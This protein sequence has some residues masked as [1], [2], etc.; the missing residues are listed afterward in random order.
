MPQKRVEAYDTRTGAKLP[1]RVPENWLRIFPYLSLTPKS[2]A[3]QSA[4]S[5]DVPVADSAEDVASTPKT[6]RRGRQTHQK[7]S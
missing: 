2:K 5:D 4:V 6:A 3:A 1:H 7:E